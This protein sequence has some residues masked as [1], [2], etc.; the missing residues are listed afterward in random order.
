[1]TINHLYK[2]FLENKRAYQLNINY[3]R[4]TLSKIFQDKS[5]DDY[6]IK[7]EFA[8]GNNFYDGNPIV[9]LVCQSKK[10]AVRIIQEK[11]ESDSIEI[12]AWLDDFQI[13]E[14]DLFDELVISLE[15]SRE[16]KKLAEK[17]IKKWIIE[18]LKD[19]QMSKFIDEQI[20][21]AH[22]EILTPPITR[23]RPRISRKKEFRKSL[24]ELSK[25]SSKKPLQI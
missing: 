12:G 6:W 8:N 25:Q 4:R 2:N 23:K 3:W 11:P 10:K 7:P 5:K 13:S 21:L 18:D 20:D 22:Q 24:V 1:V 17:L 14:E 16:S 15:L 9:F 19:S